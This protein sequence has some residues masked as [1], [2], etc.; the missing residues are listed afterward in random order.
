MNGITCKFR[1]LGQDSKTFWK[2]PRPPLSLELFCFLTPFSSH[3]LMC[4]LSSLSWWQ[5]IINGWNVSTYWL[6]RLCFQQ[7]GHREDT[8][9]LWTCQSQRRSPTWLSQEDGEARAWRSEQ[10]NTNGWLRVWL[11]YDRQVKMENSRKMNRATSHTLK[12]FVDNL[13]C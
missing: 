1:S 7:Q 9:A 11:E 10:Q 8:R 12:G 2:Q 4:C 13:S 6:G 3:L 5:L